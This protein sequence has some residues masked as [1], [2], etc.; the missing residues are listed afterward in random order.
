MEVA[1]FPRTYAYPKVLATAA[2][3][4]L[5]AYSLRKP[6]LV[7]QAL[8]AAGVRIAFLLRHDLGLFVGA[9]GLVASIL[10]MCGVSLSVDH[11]GS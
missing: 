4:W 5:I 8:L 1:T 10:A 3:L 11:V 9:G 2:G 6:S 7:R